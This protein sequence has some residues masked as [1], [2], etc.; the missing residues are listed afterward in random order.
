MAKPKRKTTPQESR[1]PMD[2]A[3]DFHEAVR[4]MD[5][6]AIKQYLAADSDCVGQLDRWGN[7]VMHICVAGGASLRPLGRE[8]M[9]FL[10]MKTKVDLLQ[11]NFEGYDPLDLAIA[12]NELSACEL[13]DP[14]WHKQ[15][16]SKFVKNEKPEL[17]SISSGPRKS[18]G[19]KLEPK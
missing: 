14:Y 9:E 17:H 3:P 16:S 1:D 13:I 7:N 15:L 11:C 8:I 2:A 5:F 4:R 18:S 6:E 19:S 10:L 12:I